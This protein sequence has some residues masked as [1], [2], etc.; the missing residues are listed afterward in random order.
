MYRFWSTALIAC[1]Y[2]LAASVP[3]TVGI[4]RPG[5]TGY[6]KAML[7][8]MIRGQ[9]YRPFVK[10][11]LVPLLI[12]SG[13]T[14]MPDP[15]RE[16]LIKAF[17]KSRLV[18]R[19]GWPPAFAPEFV[20]ALIIMYVSLIG[21][22]IVLRRFLLTFLEISSQLSH[23]IVLV[24]SVGLPITFSGLLFVYDFTQLLLF[25][26]AALCMFKHRWLSFYPLF[27]LACLNK[28]TSLLLPIVFVLWVG[29]D[30]LK[31]ANFKHVVAQVFIGVAICSTLSWIY[32]HNPGENA[33]WFLSRNMSLSFS[34]LAWVRLGVLLTG[35]ILALFQFRIAPLFLKRGFAA[36]LPVLLIATFFFG[37]IDELRDYY[38][39]LPFVVGLSLITIGRQFNI[40]PLSEPQAGA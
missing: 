20:L 35:L 24:L 25:T 17:E 12:R 40:R 5:I 13:T 2:L 4:I 15:I 3:L 11:Q 38:E 9:A 16:R 36:T 37:Y 7:E 22:L 39:A 28:E 8:D 29:L 19:L 31:R 1:A 6:Q 14:I 30:C 33:F 21:F 34:P 27:C 32:R 18:T 10:R 26:A 23:A